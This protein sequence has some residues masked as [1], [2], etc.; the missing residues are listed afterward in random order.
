MNR[1]VTLSVA[2]ALGILCLPLVG[3]APKLAAN[4]VDQSATLMNDGARIVLTGPIRCTQ[5]EWVDMR[6]TVTQRSTGATAEGRVRLQ[7]TTTTQQWEL[8]ANSQGG[9]AFEAGEAT[10]VA[11]AVA[12]SKGVA[13]DAHQWLVTIELLAD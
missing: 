3:L 10:A 2:T 6:V 5:E 4:T 12:T 7:G 1:S 8:T 11:M 13:T 9:A